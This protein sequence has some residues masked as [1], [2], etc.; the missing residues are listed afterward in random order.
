MRLAPVIAAVFL[1][2]LLSGQRHKERTFEDCDKTAATQ[3]DLTEC[4]GLDLKT[5][6]DELNATYLQLLKRAAGDPI[7][8]RKIKAAQRAWVSF[9]DAQ[10]A[11]FYP[12]EDKQKAYGSAFS[13]CADLTLADLT[14][15][16]TK[17]LKEMLNPAEGDVC[18]S[19]ATR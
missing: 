14:R 9:R 5:A 17:I 11:A 3:A 7:A 6:D 10:I 12:A 2:S 18:G 1:I 13:M 19:G 4:A 16:Q 8:V 15:E